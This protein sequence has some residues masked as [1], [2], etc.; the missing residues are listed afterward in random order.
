MMGQGSKSVSGRAPRSSTGKTKVVELLERNKNVQLPQPPSQTLPPSPTALCEGLWARTLMTARCL[1]PV[2]V[3]GS[4]R[5]LMWGIYFYACT[6]ST[7]TR[8]RYGEGCK[9]IFS[10]SL[11]LGAVRRYAREEEEEGHAGVPGASTGGRQRTVMRVRAHSRSQR[12][13][14]EG[15][16]TCEAR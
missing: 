11:G 6:S 14:G 13:V 7:S 8:G 12:A 15:G 9:C 1:P 2:D 10:E 3:Q 5:G 16:S 4:S